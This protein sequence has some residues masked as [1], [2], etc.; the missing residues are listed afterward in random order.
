LTKHEKGHEMK[1][2]GMEEESDLHKTET[3]L[4]SGL[5]KIWYFYV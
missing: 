1:V 3:I 5:I 4:V 2:E